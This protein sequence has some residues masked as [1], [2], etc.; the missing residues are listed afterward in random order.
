MELPGYDPRGTTGYALEYAVADRGGCHRRARPLIKEQDDQDFR[1]SYE[2]KAKLVRSLED[3]RGF[4]HSLLVCDFISPLFGNI[5]KEYASLL[6]LATSWEFDVESA[7]RVGER[8]M[9]LSRLFNG[10][11]GFRREDDWLPSRFFKDK[12]PRGGSE[13]QVL[14]KT[15][16]KKM[17]SEYYLERGWG[18][19]GFPTRKK[20][21]ELD[22]RDVMVDAD[23]VSKS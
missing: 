16:F 7:L 3:Q 11:C 8:A 20:L 6:T 18:E 19:T 5:L 4:Y 12:L 14:D 21:I 2:G 10:R 23:Y 1:F 22:L 9:N 13:G 15:K 17:L